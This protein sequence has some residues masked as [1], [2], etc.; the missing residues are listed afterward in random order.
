MGIRFGWKFGH[1][2]FGEIVKLGS[3]VE[4]NLNVG[5]RVGVNP[6][7]AKRA[8]RRYSLEVGAFSVQPK[9]GEKIVILGAGP[10]GLSAAAGLIGEVNVYGVNMPNVDAFVD[11]AGAPILF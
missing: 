2:M 10:I 9:Q 6:I 4:K 11:A 3:E 1:E 5:M 8:G 7:T